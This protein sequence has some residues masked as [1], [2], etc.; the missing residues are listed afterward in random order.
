MK[1]L[2]LLLP[3]LLT[4]TAAYANEIRLSCTG[5]LDYSAIKGSDAGMEYIKTSYEEM[6]IKT[7]SREIVINKEYKIGTISEIDGESVNTHERVPFFETTTQYLLEVKDK[8]D[9][10]FDQIYQHQIDRT[11][12]SYTYIWQVK[13]RANGTL[14]WQTPFFG[15]CIKQK[16]VKTLF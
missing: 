3:L 8:S 11:D 12:G 4:P 15:K 14:M 1:R 16:R 6:G 10:D 9:S 13:A 7:Y 5:E 2:L